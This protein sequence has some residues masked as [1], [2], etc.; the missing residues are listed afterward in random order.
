[1][2]I[3]DL[4]DH[5][6]VLMSSELPFH[7]KL[8]EKVFLPIELFFLLNCGQLIATSGRSFARPCTPRIGNI[9]K[10]KALSASVPTLT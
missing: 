6:S 4:F 1:M 3:L 10:T 8:E 2:I 9:I 5:S 7:H